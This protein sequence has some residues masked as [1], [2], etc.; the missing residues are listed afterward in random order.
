MGA[1]PKNFMG[2]GCGHRGEGVELEHANPNRL[3]ERRFTVTSHESNQ[4]HETVSW[5]CNDDRQ[6]EWTCLETGQGRHCEAG[7]AKRKE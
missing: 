3:S 1:P 2:C 7:L 6:A 4:T 5:W